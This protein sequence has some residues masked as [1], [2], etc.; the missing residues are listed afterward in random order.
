MSNR[1]VTILIVLATQWIIWLCNTPA[2]F[3][4]FL[5][6]YYLPCSNWKFLYKL[7]TVLQIIMFYGDHMHSAS[8]GIVPHTLFISIII[9]KWNIHYATLTAT[10][11]QPI[12]QQYESRKDLCNESNHYEN[13]YGAACPSYI[14]VPHPSVLLW[15]VKYPLC[16]VIS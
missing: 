10:Y 5:L 7:F 16:F 13:T 14:M 15:K 8:N 11:A 9:W 12:T 2:C 6:I 1:D 4:T 3:S